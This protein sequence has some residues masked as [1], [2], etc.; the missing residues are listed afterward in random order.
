MLGA[1]PEILVTAL[2]IYF[3]DNFLHVVYCSVFCL[4]D[5]FILST[6]GLSLFFN[7]L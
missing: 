3:S 5:F 1:T 2:Q 4:A 7:T 6:I